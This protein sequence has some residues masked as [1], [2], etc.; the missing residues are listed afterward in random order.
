M[1]EK[2]PPISGNTLLFELMRVAVLPIW[3]ETWPLGDPKAPV[4]VAERSTVDG[5]QNQA[6]SPPGQFGT[7]LEGG[8]KSP[9]EPLSIKLWVKV[10]LLNVVVKFPLVLAG[11]AVTPEGTLLA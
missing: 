8:K 3:K 4:L 9:F 6:E 10:V 7:W 11:K 2:L 1:A 5:G